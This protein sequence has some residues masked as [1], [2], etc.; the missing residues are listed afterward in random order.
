LVTKYFFTAF[1]RA[2]DS[3]WLLFAEPTES[4]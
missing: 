2:T 1:A 4:V 3:F